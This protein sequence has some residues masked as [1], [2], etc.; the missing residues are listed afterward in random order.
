MDDLLDS[1]DELHYEELITLNHAIV[2]RIKELN[3]IKAQSQLQQ[4][5]VGNQVQFMSSEGDLII[6][7]IVRLNKKTIS[8]V[9]EAGARWKVSPGLLRKLTNAAPMPSDQGVIELFD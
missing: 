8:L 2:A 3:A 6:G 1:L 7:T 5:R 9:T 4:F